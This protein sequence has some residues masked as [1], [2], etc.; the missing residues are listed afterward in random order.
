MEIIKSLF[1]GIWL[2][3]FG[4]IT[5]LY[6]VLYRRLPRS[7]AIGSSVFAAYMTYNPFWWAGVLACFMLSFV[8]V[9]SWPGRPIFWI[10]LAVT[11]LLP[12]GMLTMFLILMFKVNAAR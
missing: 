8:I 2:V 10:A 3:S 6:F 1:L 12:A 4:T 9:K 5:Y 7:T 11:E